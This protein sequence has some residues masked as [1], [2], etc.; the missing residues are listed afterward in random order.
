M[1]IH[2]SPLTI[3]DQ[4]HLDQAIAYT[5]IG[6]KTPLRTWSFPQHYIWKDLFTFSWTDMDG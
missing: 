3:K 1:S 4:V 6:G 2:L 5:C